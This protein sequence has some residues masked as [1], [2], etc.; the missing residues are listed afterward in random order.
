MG[1]TVHRL[2]NAGL[3]DLLKRRLDLPLCKVAFSKEAQESLSIGG[4]TQVL[5]VHRRLK[6]FTKTAI[7][8]W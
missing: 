8:E 7:V 5:E 6:D 4:I 1:D 2:N 3:W